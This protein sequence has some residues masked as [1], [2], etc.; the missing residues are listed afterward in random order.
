VA[1]T[2]LLSAVLFDAIGGGPANLSIT[3]A[4]TGP[5]GATVPLMFT[6][7]IAVMVR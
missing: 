3:G 7:P 2:G 4:G 5:R 6:P 1:G